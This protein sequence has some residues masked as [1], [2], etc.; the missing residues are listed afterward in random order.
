[1][2]KLELGCFIHYKEQFLEERYSL[3]IRTVGYPD[4]VIDLET[5]K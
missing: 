5:L 1:M 3:Y 4:K 2:S